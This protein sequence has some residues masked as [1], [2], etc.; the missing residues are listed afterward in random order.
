MSENLNIHNLKELKEL[1]QGLRKSMP[2]SEARL[3]NAMKGRQLEGRKFRRQHS[4]DR[5]IVDFYCPEEKLVVEVDGSSHDNVGTN[6]SDEERDK[7]MNSLGI[8]VL[9]IPAIELKNQ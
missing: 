2:Y 9:R 8:K 4:I 1:R 3:W 5:Y 7:Y 6:L